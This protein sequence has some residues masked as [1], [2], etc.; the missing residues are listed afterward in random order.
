M[1]NKE[2]YDNLFIENFS[3]NKKDLDTNI[4]YNSIPK[5]DSLEHMSFIANLEESFDIM[6]DMN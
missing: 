1:T 3:V 5:W 2:K 6:M 4:E